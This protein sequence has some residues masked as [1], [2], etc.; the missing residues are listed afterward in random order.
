MFIK[1]Q[2]FPF[3]SP[4]SPPFI[5]TSSIINFENI[6]PPSPPIYSHTPVYSVLWYII[7]V[8]LWI[9]WKFPKRIL[10]NTFRQL[11]VNRSVRQGCPKR[12]EIILVIQQ[13]IQ[14]PTK[15][16]IQKLDWLLCIIICS[17]FVK[18]GVLQN[19]YLST[20]ANYLAPLSRF[21]QPW[22]NIKQKSYL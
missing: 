2:C 12:K 21:L 11:L 4:L 16:K 17:S 14:H 8:S 18:S 6:P 22:N 9:L 15:D 20:L 7:K 1:I 13:V 19:T 10:K 3:S 5:S